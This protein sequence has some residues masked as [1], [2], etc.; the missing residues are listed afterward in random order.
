MDVVA[1]NVDDRLLTVAQF[2]AALLVIHPFVDG[3]GRMAR[4]ILMQ[5]F[6]DLFGHANL[7]LMEQGAGYYRALASA[8]NGDARPLANVLK[9]V[10]DG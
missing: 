5:Q 6:L 7:S 3:N 1:G 10:A 9:P 4:A 8:D 2:H